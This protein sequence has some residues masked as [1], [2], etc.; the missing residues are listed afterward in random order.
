[1]SQGLSIVRHA[2]RSA[3]EGFA[4]VQNFVFG[5]GHTT[6]AVTFG[7]GTSSPLGS[8]DAKRFL[9]ATRPVFDE[10]YGEITAASEPDARFDLSEVAH[11]EL[12]N[13]LS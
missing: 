7:G 4:R 6:G 3:N 9:D 8:D 10:M 1:M 5:S 11:D 13:W 12:G 2:L